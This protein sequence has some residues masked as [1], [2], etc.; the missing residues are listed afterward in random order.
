MVWL[1]VTGNNGSALYF[2]VERLERR[3]A[4]GKA[5][6]EVAGLVG[7]GQYEGQVLL[8]VAGE[9]E[10]TFLDAWLR[11]RAFQDFL[12]GLEPEQLTAALSEVARRLAETLAGTSAESLPA[13]SVRTGRN[14][15]G[16]VAEGRPIWR[17]VA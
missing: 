6:T 15:L 11:P 3:T 2:V 14:V 8:E 7:D 10:V 13:K 9:V 1:E 4:A 17:Q 5:R 12:Q 16:R